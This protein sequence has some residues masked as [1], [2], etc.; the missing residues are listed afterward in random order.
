MGEVQLP[1][2]SGLDQDVQR[3]VDRR[4][5]DLGQVAIDPALDL[6]GRGMIGLAEHILA[7]GEALCRGLDTG[8]LQSGFN[9]RQG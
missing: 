5:A 4:Q 1:Q 8:R 2:Q 3:V 9:F 7:N 6:F